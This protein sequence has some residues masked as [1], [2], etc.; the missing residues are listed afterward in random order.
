MRRDLGNLSAIE[1]I[2]VNAAFA[3][4]RQEPAV[5]TPVRRLDDAVKFLEPHDFAR[6]DV[7]NFQERLVSR[8]VPHLRRRQFE[9]VR[10][11]PTLAEVVHLRHHLHGLRMRHRLA[12]QKAFFDSVAAGQDLVFVAVFKTRRLLRF[13]ERTR[14]VEQLDFHHVVQV[15]NADKAV[16][17]INHALVLERR[18]HGRLEVRHLT[19][20]VDEVDPVRRIGTGFKLDALAL[21]LYDM[22]F[23]STADLRIGQ[24][25]IGKREAVNAEVQK[26]TARE[27]RV[28]Q[29]FH[30]RQRHREIGFHA[31]DL[32]DAPRQNPILHHLHGG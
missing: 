8:T 26:R 29:A 3:V 2:P 6:F 32:A 7:K 12:F 10:N 18:H 4:V 1:F 14:L 25:D 15:L 11:A 30:M 5:G 23:R 17:P 21:G 9:R 16:R 22:V 28:A 31:F 19:V 13:H 27:R 20:F 24:E